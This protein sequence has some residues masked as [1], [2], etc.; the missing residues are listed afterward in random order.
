[1]DKLSDKVK[2]LNWIYCSYR[3]RYNISMSGLRSW[4]VPY[5]CQ[6]LYPSSVLSVKRPSCQTSVKRPICQVSYFYTLRDIPCEQSS[7]VIEVSCITA[8]YVYTRP[9]MVWG[10]VIASATDI[11]RPREQVSHLNYSYVVGYRY[12]VYFECVN[13]VCMIVIVSFMW[14]HGAL[15]VIKCTC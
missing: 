12:R 10:T 13:C 9:Y 11:P 2:R 8:T 15:S 6:A 5:I 7:E 4:L 14:L 3:I 1:M